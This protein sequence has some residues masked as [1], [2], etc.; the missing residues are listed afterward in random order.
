MTVRVVGFRVEPRKADFIP[1]VDLEAVIEALSDIYREH[2]DAE[3]YR[4]KVREFLT[5]LVQL[6]TPAA[7]GEGVK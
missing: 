7:A 2:A 1:V 4:D 3:D 6:T 5:E